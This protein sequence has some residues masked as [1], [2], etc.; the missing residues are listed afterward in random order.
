[1]PCAVPASCVC[2]RTH[3]ITHSESCLFKEAPCSLFRR[4][5]VLRSLPR[6]S[7]YNVLCDLGENDPVADCD[8]VGAQ[9][10]LF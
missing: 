8:M 3:L 9:E 2:E 7:P 5:D 1:M 4:P 10:L 6:R